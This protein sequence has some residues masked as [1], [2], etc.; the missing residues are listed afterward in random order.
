LASLTTLPDNGGEAVDTRAVR[1]VQNQID[2]DV[3]PTT[4]R[5]LL[6]PSAPRE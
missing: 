2:A 4:A 1:D 3:R 5:D 6:D